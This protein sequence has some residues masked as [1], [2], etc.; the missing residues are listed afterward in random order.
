M[1]L[2]TQGPTANKELK[3][4]IQT[5]ISISHTQPPSDATVPCIERRKKQEYMSKLNGNNSSQHLL[6]VYRV[7]SVHYDIGGAHYDY[8]HFT[9]ER[10]EAWRDLKTCPR[11]SQEGETWD[12]NLGRLTSKLVP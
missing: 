7:L 8:F 12:L 6:S 9:D 1:K 5:Q 11:I 4:R 3:T 2:S 10:N